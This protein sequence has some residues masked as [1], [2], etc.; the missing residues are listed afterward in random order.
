MKSHPLLLPA[1]V[2]ALAFPAAARADK[3][4]VKS[5]QIRDAVTS[6]AL[7]KKRQAS[8]QNDPFR[9][10]GPPA[11]NQEADPAKALAGRDLIKDSTILCYRGYLT[12]VPKQSV[13]HI[14]EGLKDRI[15]E[16][17]GVEIKGWKEF[18]RTN[19]GWI[20]TVEV[21]R[22]QVLGYKP[23]PETT[24]NAIANST[25]LV[26]AT[27]KDGPVSVLP[28]KEEED[29]PSALEQKSIIYRK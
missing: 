14:P 22:D 10:V 25:S 19:R 4:A 21:T 7:A 26:V 5:S 24:L 1:F 18:Y 3:P 27:F 9:K 13:L 12:L 17:K 8:S 23:L 20:R 15:G 6:E 16:K 2:V 11:G 29:I 28:L